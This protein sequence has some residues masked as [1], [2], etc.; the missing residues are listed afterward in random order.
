MQR[1]EKKQDR[2]AVAQNNRG[3]KQVTRRANQQTHSERLIPFS[4]LW[5]FGSARPLFCHHYLH[6]I[7]F[8]NRQIQIETT[9][10]P[11]TAPTQ[12]ISCQKKMMSSQIA[13][14]GCQAESTKVQHQQERTKERAERD[15]R[16]LFWS[17]GAPFD[18]RQHGHHRRHASWLFVVV[19]CPPSEPMTI[20]KSNWPPVRPVET[21]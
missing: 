2:F 17:P 19:F 12:T 11:M 10:T 8:L 20:I 7:V 3:G 21:H 18:D 4:S 15:R 14:L 9:Q 6:E 13:S 1:V 16:S 5:K